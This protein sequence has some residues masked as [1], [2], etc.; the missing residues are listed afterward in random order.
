MIYSIKDFGP[1]DLLTSGGRFVRRI[2]VDSA[3]SDDAAYDQGRRFRALMPF[4]LGNGEVK[5]YRFEFSKDIDLKLATQDV[6][7]GALLYEV[8]GTD[9]V[10]GGVFGQSVDV[11][12]ANLKSV[13]PTPA[14]GTT[15]TTGGTLDISSAKISDVQYLEVSQKQTIGESQGTM[16]GFPPTV[17]YVRIST[18]G[19]GAAPKGVLKY[20]WTE[21]E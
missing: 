20:E 3:T 9:A 11:L 5:V 15:I 17:A 19:N 1:S 2:K 10:Q 4:A 12:R 13:A 18:L 7:D 21:A 16:R 6:Y 8:Y 14:T